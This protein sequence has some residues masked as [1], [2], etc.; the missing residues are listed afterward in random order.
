MNIYKL[1]YT[2]KDNA[3]ADLISKGVYIETEE[4]L[5]YGEG[6]QAIVEIGKLVKTDGVY[7]ENF[8]EITAPVYYDGVFYDVMCIKDIEFGTNEVFPIDS[9]HSF[10]GYN[11]NA[12]GPVSEVVITE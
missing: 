4:S 7:D 8:N 10:A 5:Y 11:P 9:V 3:T 6:V 12:D 2:D 1:N